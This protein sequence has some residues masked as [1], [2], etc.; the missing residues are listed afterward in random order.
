MR[1]EKTRE[2]EKENV[3]KKRKEIMKKETNKKIFNL[4]FFFFLHMDKMTSFLC[5]KATSFWDELALN[6]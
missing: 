1:E 2:K 5:I 4:T 6:N 3:K